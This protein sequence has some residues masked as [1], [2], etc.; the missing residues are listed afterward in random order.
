MIVWYT[1]FQ[2]KFTCTIFLPIPHLPLHLP[3]QDLDLVDPS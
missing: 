3:P 2:L 1:S